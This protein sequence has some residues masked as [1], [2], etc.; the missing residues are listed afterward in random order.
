MRYYCNVCNETITEAI[1]RYSMSHH[2]KALCTK[3]QK[4][5]TSQAMRLSEALKKLDIQH[6][7]EYS[8]GHKHVDIAIPWAKLFLEIEGQQYTFSPKQ[9]ISDHERD[10]HSLTAGFYTMR[11]PNERVDKDVDGV[12]QSVARLA[13]YM[14]RKIKEEEKK[15]TLTGLLKIGYKTLSNWAEEYDKSDYY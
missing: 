1:Y 10:A 5:V 13:R 9:M 4:T 14:F 12:A 7:L 6:T 3:H 15:H 8:D 11:I 2:G